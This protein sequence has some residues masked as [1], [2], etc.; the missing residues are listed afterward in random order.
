M[1]G[2]KAAAE[3]TQEIKA[4]RMDV[5]LVEFNLEGDAS[6]LVTH[7]W[8]EK[9]KKEMRDKQQK[10]V[11]GPRAAKDPEAECEAARYLDAE[12]RDCLPA[13]AFKK[14]IVDAASFSDDATKVILRG[15]VFVI[16]ELVVIDYEK[17]EMREDVV[18]VQMSSD[19]RYRPE[20][21]GWKVK[22]PV[23][24][25]ASQLSIDQLVNFVARAGFSIGVGEHRPQKNGQNGRFKI[26]SFHEVPAAG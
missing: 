10:K 3:Q 23:Q 9:A 18:R 16:G 19:L 21:T 8:S 20:Y 5:R 17:R 25:D 26:K 11:R 12:G 24:Y 4:K 14:A 7:K 6:V 15:S 13:I 1:A 2:K 22:L